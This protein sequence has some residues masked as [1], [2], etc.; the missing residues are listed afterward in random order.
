V[1]PLR[2]QGRRFHAAI[3]RLPAD[4]DRVVSPQEILQRAWDAHRYGPSKVLDVHVAAL[5]KKLG[6]P[7]LIETVYGHGFRFGER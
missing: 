6:L 2:P 7:G 4:P 3:E 1:F 5:R